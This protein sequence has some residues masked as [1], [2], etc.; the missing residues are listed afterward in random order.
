LGGYH[1]RDY[2]YDVRR[3]NCIK[4]DGTLTLL[5]LSLIIAQL[6][7]ILRLPHEILLQIAD[8]LLQIGEC[9]L[10]NMSL[11]CRTLFHPAAS[12]LYNS[13]SFEVIDTSPMSSLKWTH[14]PQRL[15]NVSVDNGVFVK[16]LTISFVSFAREWKFISI[17]RG[18]EPNQVALSVLGKCCG[19]RVLHLV[20]ADMGESYASYISRKGL[21]FMKG[22]KSN[23][24]PFAT[25]TELIISSPLVTFRGEKAETLRLFPSLRILTL[26][27][28]EDSVVNSAET[29]FSPSIYTTRGADYIHLILDI[30]ALGT[31]CPYLEQ[32]NLPLWE[33]AFVHP[34]VCAALS[35]LPSLRQISFHR[36]WSQKA[37]PDLEDYIGFRLYL[38]NHTRISVVDHEPMTYLAMKNL[39]HV[40]LRSAEIM[41]DY[42]Y[43]QLSNYRMLHLR[44]T[45]VEFCFANSRIFN[46]YFVSDQSGFQIL[47]RI[48]LILCGNPPPSIDRLSRLFTSLTLS[49]THLTTFHSWLPNLYEFVASPFL[50]G[51]SLQ[52][53]HGRSLDFPLCHKP[54]GNTSYTETR[55]EMCRWKRPIA[56]PRGFE[57]INLHHHWRYFGDNTASCN[58]DENL[59]IPEFML[60]SKCT[61]YEWPEDE[62]ELDIMEKYGMDMRYAVPFEEYL[63]H[64]ADRAAYVAFHLD[65]QIFNIPETQ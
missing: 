20:E 30:K 11:T 39:S 58:H 28:P 32:W 5:R 1:H 51:L 53:H 25:V 13:L 10:S 46:Q 65:V 38:Q 62:G 6:P 3:K 21:H 27:W 43:D 29:F 35:K 36:Q 31:H 18:W 9:H 42:L 47:K 61:W 8:V 7:P 24:S 34:N 59:Q 19:L 45:A 50:R 55:F 22:W 15:K 41:L 2:R 16:K 37:P 49:V 26:D 64:L 56:A 63:I 4:E 52:F 44:T 14:K 57:A 48:N 40:S 12:V 17:V 23:H 33:P 54:S 60:T